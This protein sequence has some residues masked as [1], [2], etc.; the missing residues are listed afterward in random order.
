[1]KTNSV[2]HSTYAISS[3]IFENCQVIGEKNQLYISSNHILGLIL[4]EKLIKNL[5][6]QDFSKILDKFHFSISI[7]S[8][9]HSTFTSQKS[10]NFSLFHFS[11]KRESI[12]F[13]TFHFLNFLN[14]LSLGPGILK[15]PFFVA[16]LP[17]KAFIQVIFLS[18]RI[19][20]RFLHL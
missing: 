8:H 7:L 16:N 20:S 10:Q 6:S 4:E 18:I 1:M 19:L 9:F 17:N 15:G 3:C 2:C 13:F 14:P 12:F 5:V 11:D